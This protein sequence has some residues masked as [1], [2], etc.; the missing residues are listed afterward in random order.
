MRP[1]VI[2]RPTRRHIAPRARTLI[3]LVAAAIASAGAAFAL[4]N[5]SGTPTRPITAV[6]AEAP[7]LYA[8][9][10]VEV[11]GMPVG[12]IT[13]VQPGPA[14]VTV[15]MKVD[16]S[17]SI[18]AN[19]Q[20]YLVA[21]EVVNDRYVELTPAYSGGPVMGA[22]TVIPE[23][24]THIPLSVDAVLANLDSLFNAL[25]PTV[26]DPHGAL[27]SLVD[28]LN[29]ELAGQGPALHSTIDALGQ[30]SSDL[31]TDGPG[32]AGTLSNLSPFIT[33]AAADTR[34]YQTFSTNLSVVSQEL[35]ADS[36]ALAGTLSTLQQTLAQLTKFIQANQTH[37]GNSL[38]NLDTLSTALVSK[39]K[40]LAD[41]LQVT[42]LALDNLDTAIYK[43]DPSHPRLTARVDF[44]NG[45]QAYTDQICGSEELRFVDLLAGD[46]PA[47]LNPQHTSPASTLDLGC[48]FGTGAQNV[49][50]PPGAPSIPDLSISGLVGGPR[51]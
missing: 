19:A 1:A 28:D 30:A 6:F 20:A 16:R 24:R 8:G 2:R 43:T 10:H 51:P 22:G 4:V 50:V 41:I 33:A 37:L 36:G 48:V 18:P 27:A 9:N 17:V 13:S 38:T 46:V 47:A 14:G 15:Q 29:R 12:T 7:A 32:L 23:S 5:R 34:D 42:P 44:I 49:G 21:S 35:N 26:S 45:T 39:E 25:A 11:L 31:A 3:A 40:D